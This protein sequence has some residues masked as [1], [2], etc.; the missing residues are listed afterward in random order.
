MT[1]SLPNAYALAAFVGLPYLATAL[2]VIVTLQRYLFRRFTYSS[3]SSQFL[4]NDAHF[5][6]LVPFHY[7]LLGVLGLH[8]FALCLPAPLLAFTRVPVRLYLLEATGFTLGLLAVAGMAMALLRR[9]G[10]RK[11]FVVTSPMD[12]IL[13]ALLLLQV[14]TG[15]FVAVFKPWGYAW[16]SA[17]VAP[18]FLSLLRLNPDIS[19]ISVLPWLVQLHLLNAFLLMA[20]FPFTRLVHLAVAPLPYLWRRPQLVRWY[21][22]PGSRLGEDRP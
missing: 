4:E 5:W 7:G 6:A 19:A 1:G 13:L 14:T 9:T 11:V 18:Y 17:I 2:M 12:W 3:L 20:V 8:A 21:A 16:F 10:S 22:K 15:L